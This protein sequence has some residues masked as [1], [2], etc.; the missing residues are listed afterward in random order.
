[1]VAFAAVGIACHPAVSMGLGLKMGAAYL[2][3]HDHL[4]ELG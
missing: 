3:G 2:N 4:Q 1:M